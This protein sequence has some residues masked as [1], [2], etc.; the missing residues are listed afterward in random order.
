[1]S[2]NIYKYWVTRSRGQRA[3]NAQ[4]LTVEDF[5]LQSRSEN[6]NGFSQV[7]QHKVNREAV[8]MWINLQALVIL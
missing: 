4:Q 6:F 7:H 5:G 1:M 8:S 3:T 2:L